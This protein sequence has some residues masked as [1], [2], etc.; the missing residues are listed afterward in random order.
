MSS[1]F[2]HEPTVLFLIPGDMRRQTGGSLYNRKL[3]EGLTERG[4]RLEIVAL[5]DLPYFAGLV[6]GLFIT[7]ILLLRFARRKFDL[8]IEDGWAHPTTFL[9]NVVCRL[10]GKV[11]LVIIVHQIRWHAI[12]PPVRSVALIVEQLALRSAH[13][14]FTVSAFISGEV[15]RLVGSNSQIAIAS[16]GSEPPSGS[17]CP[18]RD[19]THQPL[20]LLFVGNCTRLKGLDHLVAALSLLEDLDLRLDI[21]GDVSLEPRYFVGLARKAKTLGVDQRVIFHGAISPEDLGPLYSQADIFTFPSLYEGFGIVLGEAMHA[22]LPIVATRTGPVNEIVREGENALIVP[23]ADSEALACAIRKLAA[24]P[25]M[26]RDF[27]RRSQELAGSLPTWKQ[28]CDIVSQKITVMIR[29]TPGTKQKTKTI[30]TR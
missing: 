12:R 29:T 30:P 11:R 9:F 4:F 18:R 19:S 26:R 8:V 21:V 2:L 20:R 15:E 17:G 24:D 22:G 27:G 23:P 5:P 3:A 28:T 7:P 16:P 6:A 14:I 13:L 25:A 10:V 1:Q